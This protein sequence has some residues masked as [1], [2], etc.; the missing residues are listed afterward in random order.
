MKQNEIEKNTGPSAP[1][2]PAAT[3]FTP[4]VTMYGNKPA[5]VWRNEKGITHLL[6][7]DG[8]KVGSN[9]SFPVVRTLEVIDGRKSRYAITKMGYLDLCDGNFVDAKTAAAIDA[10]RAKSATPAAEAPTTAP[11]AAPAPTKAPTFSWKDWWKIKPEQSWPT[12]YGDAQASW[13]WQ[14]RALDGLNELAKGGID[15]LT[16]SIKEAL[17]C[18]DTS[19][20]EMTK[21]VGEAQAAI[22]EF[23][24]KT[25][26]DILK[27]QDTPDYWEGEREEVRW[28]PLTAAFPL[29][30]E[31]T[32]TDSEISEKLEANA[33]TIW[34]DTDGFECGLTSSGEIL[35][36]KEGESVAMS[37][38]IR[39]A[40]L[41][42]LKGDKDSFLFLTRLVQ[43]VYGYH[44][45]QLTLF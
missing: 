24:Q 5:L 29:S 22:L 43:E 16:Q 15:I 21:V 6:T 38:H 30:W 28:F 11:P 3:T 42:E 9:K 2:S 34:V 37:V 44:P 20:P 36:A 33:Y 19:L 31:L 18:Y 27:S 25:K 39:N 41:Y 35:L 26:A 40:D 23:S 13:D 12:L 7:A 17:E 32:I 8:Q 14:E 45:D 4:Y 10:F 1:A